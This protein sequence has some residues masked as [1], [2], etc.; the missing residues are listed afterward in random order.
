MLIL[1]LEGRNS[2]FSDMTIQPALPYVVLTNIYHFRQLVITWH[3]APL[4]SLIM[5]SDDILIYK[6][7]K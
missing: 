7:P 5:C 1:V 2:S 6:T 3:M 4:D